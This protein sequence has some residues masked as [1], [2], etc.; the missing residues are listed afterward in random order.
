M[1]IVRNIKT[2]EII[3]TNP[4]PLAQNLSDK[5]VYFDFDPATMETGKTDDDIPEYYNINAEG[6]IEEFTLQQ[7]L[8]AG[9]IALTPEEKI[10][11]DQ[12]VEKTLSEKVKDKL[13]TLQPS[14]KIIGEGKEEQIVEKT[15]SEQLAE[16]LI[17]LLPTQKIVGVGGNEKI[18]DKPIQEMLDEKIITLD[19]IKKR[20][21]EEFSSLSLLHRHSILPNYKIQNALMGIY[22]D[23]IAAA[24]KKTIEAFRK[25][26]HRLEGVIDEAA[27]LDD[28]DKIKAKFPKSLAGMKKQGQRNSSRGD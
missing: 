3:H 7:K 24:Y 2:K 28:L 10:E 19:E 25:E 23:E 4:A 26:Y 16:S 18:V 6:I 21:I 1:Y 12:I 22:D 15:L 5:E 8:D 11:N 9:I 20:K 14:Q 17:T 13:M 27:S